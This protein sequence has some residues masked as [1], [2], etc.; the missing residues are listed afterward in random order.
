MAAVHLEV[1]FLSAMGEPCGANVAHGSCKQSLTC[2]AS[3]IPSEIAAWKRVCADV[4]SQ[5]VR[6]IVKLQSFYWLRAARSKATKSATSSIEARPAAAALA[7]ELAELS[8]P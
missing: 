4:D 1:L 2:G 3:L 7:T 5:V 6:V 8:T